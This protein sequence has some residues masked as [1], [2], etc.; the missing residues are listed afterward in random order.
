[1]APGV[2]IPVAEESGLITELGDWALEE[3]ARQIVDWQQRG[4]PVP[5]VAVNLSPRQLRDSDLAGRIENLLKAT[6]APPGALELEITESAAMQHPEGAA[7]A[8]R[9][10]R[11][12]G[13]QL[14]LDDFGTG[15][16]S[17]AVLSSLPLHVLKLDRSFVQHLPQ[18]RTDA[19]VAGAVVT[20]ARQFEL[21]V[22]AEGVETD[23][24]RRFLADLGCDILQGFLFARPMASGALE[25]W[26][27]TGGPGR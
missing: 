18:S 10:L 24:Q 14:A 2:F 21:T 4:I 7:F 19:A 15:Y 20:L 1:M 6:G 8:L 13:V 3:A 16:S 12:R 23:N 27:V 26:L 17:L 11:E 9:R 25:E 22:V 5:R